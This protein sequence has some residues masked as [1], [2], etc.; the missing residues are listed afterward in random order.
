VTQSR[1]VLGPLRWLER[2]GLNGARRLFAAHQPLLDRL[3]KAGVT[4]P[5]SPIGFGADTDS[6]HYDGQ[7]PPHPPVFVY[8]GT[9]SEWHGPH[10][11]IDAL[12]GVLKEHPGAR[13]IYYGNGEERQALRE[14]AESL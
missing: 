11:F 12:P 8:A 9:Y 10:I 1:F 7:Q 4:A 6:F 14:R 3:R 5:A 2:W 13:L